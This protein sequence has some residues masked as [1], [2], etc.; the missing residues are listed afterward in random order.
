MVVYCTELS[1]SVRVQCSKI[2]QSL[3]FGDF[4]KVVN[5]TA[6]DIEYIDSSLFLLYLTLNSNFKA[7]RASKSLKKM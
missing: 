6:I 3:C 5:G 4:S 7:Q 2:F 1:L